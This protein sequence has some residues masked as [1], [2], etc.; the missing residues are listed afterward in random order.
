M[1][2]QRILR[3][4]LAAVS[5]SALAVTAMAQ[6][7]YSSDRQMHRGMM[8][9][10]Q[11]DPGQMGMMPRRGTMGPGQMGGPPGMGPMG[12]MH[13][14]G[15]MSP[16]MMQQLNLSADQ[17]D[18]V[19]DIMHENHKSNY[20]KM[21]KM[22]DLQYE[23]QK[24]MNQPEPDPKEAGKVMDKM[25]AIKREMME[26]RIKSQNQVRGV[27]NKQQQERFD[28]MRHGGMGMM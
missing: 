18:K 6:S 7:G 19:R 20:E 21:G 22:M 11:Q 10:N 16:M 5:M 24:L 1:K 26:N 28:A 12:G 23:M 25:S 8:M 15:P 9:Q 17:W 3:L 2:I 27:L 14:M 13:G 4:L